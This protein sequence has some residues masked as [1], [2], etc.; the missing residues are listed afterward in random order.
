MSAFKNTG[1]ILKT[2]YEGLQ[3]LAIDPFVGVQEQAI[4]PL[5]CDYIIERAR[6]QMRPAGV[7]LKE[8][9]DQS[10]GRSGSSCWLRYAD[11]INIG[12]I[13]QRIA[14]AVG[15]PLA[16][17]ESMQVIHYGVNQEYRHHFDAYN[18]TSKK[19]QRA[20][21][22]GGQRLV[23][24]LVYLNDVPAGGGTDFSKLA[25]SI[26]ARAGRMVVFHNTR[27][28][29]SQPHPDSLH[30]GLPVLGGEKWAFNI[31]FHYQPV[32]QQYQFDGARY[33]PRIRFAASPAKRVPSAC[34]HLHVLSNR[35]ARLWQ[36]A[37]SACPPNVS[38][39][40]LISYWDSYG[41][42][43]LPDDAA[44][45]YA[46]HIQLIARRWTNPL[47]NKRTFS[48]ML[49][50]H[51]LQSIAPRSFD[52]AG[53]ASA[54]ANGTEMMWFVKNIFGTAGVDM[55]CVKTD[56]LSLI[57][58]EDDYILQEGITDLALIDGKK[59]VTRVYLLC[60]NKSLFLSD[61]AF[62]VIHGEP[63]E[64][65]STSYDVQ[66]N[67]AGYIDKNSSIRLIALDDCDY[68]DTIMQRSDDLGRELKPVLADVFSASSEAH[69]AILGLDVLLENT[70]ALRLIEINNFPNFT[71]TN[72][73]NEQVNIPFFSSVLDCLTG[74]VTAGL[75]IL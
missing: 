3:T 29:A 16:H 51:N 49:H 24:A 21:K 37:A 75:K 74:T 63:Y 6:D 43:A 4:S 9:N 2:H 26:D 66:I 8:K 10:A 68:A 25:I 61:K 57:E 38:V 65:D 42:K 73:I 23:T 27:E 59:F 70:G 69:Y 64:R 72:R 22:W 14:T 5:E 50:E 34:P 28:D 44:A 19:G 36:R 67:H 60:Y 12:K 48:D 71:H 47:S 40:T 11:D 41:G 54:Y 32:R 18:L 33:P 58:L 35:S 46:R 31:W 53:D 15:L 39:D 17:A 30:A 7:V 45:G 20:A 56:E 62:C 55:H 13:G 52:S 1:L